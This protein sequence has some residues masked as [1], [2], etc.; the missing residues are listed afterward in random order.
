MFS[1]NDLTA[2]D[3]GKKYA[4]VI[5]SFNLNDLSVKIIVTNDDDICSADWSDLTALAES[6]QHD[7]VFW[8]HIHE[9]NGTNDQ[10]LYGKIF[11]K[12][13][14]TENKLNRGPDPFSFVLGFLGSFATDALMQLGINYL[15]DEVIDEGDWTK[16]AQKIN[17]GSSFVSGIMGG[18]GL[19]LKKLKYAAS[20]AIALGTVAYNV[21]TNSSYSKEEGVRDF[22][23]T[24]ITS[25]IGISAGPHIVGKL[26][27]LGID[28][29][30][31]KAF[32]KF[33][34]LFRDGNSL[35]KKEVDLA[36]WLS[37]NG[38][39]SILNPKIRGLQMQQWA[40]ESYYKTLGYKN[41]GDI[42]EFFPAIDFY[43][44]A[45]KIGISV[46]T[47]NVT[48]YEGLKKALQKNIV[49]L[50]TFKDARLIKYNQK[51]YPLE[52]TKLMVLVPEENVS[53]VNNK[54]IQLMNEL[55][56][57]NKINSIEVKSIE[58]LLNL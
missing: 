43:H 48:T 23:V 47:T 41:M 13:S 12:D 57:S 11:Y 54:V 6:A 20:G 38:E 27:N 26:K 44:F 5:D 10:F 56:P 42:S 25:Y 7:V 28:R 32:K 22:I 52:Q 9:G 40:Y 33:S 50:Q 49:D 4:A 18:L 16:A 2:V 35:S 31:S 30:S 1:I 21:A 53:T 58:M 24:F 15:I 17:Y 39:S 55:D 51:D 36:W 29:L 14:D 3:I 45:S 46:K 37:A 19:D 34:S 8:H